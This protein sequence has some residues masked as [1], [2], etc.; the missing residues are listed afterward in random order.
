MFHPGV[1]NNFINFISAP[2]ILALSFAFTI[3][4]SLTHKSVSK[5]H[6]KK[7]AERKTRRRSNN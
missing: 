1:P 5:L 7:S 4:H 3:Q 2:I 6:V